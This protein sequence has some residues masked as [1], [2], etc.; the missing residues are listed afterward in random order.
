MVV[1]SSVIYIN[2]SSFDT[3][4]KR[5][6]P[7]P[8]CAGLTNILRTGL[9]TIESFSYLNQSKMKKDVHSIKDG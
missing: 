2:T 6:F 8:Q 4:E 1:S 7:G 3:L 5:R 9:K